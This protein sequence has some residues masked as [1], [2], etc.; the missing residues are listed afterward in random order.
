[1][2]TEVIYCGDN[3]DVLPRYVDDESVDLVYIDPPF[4]T[5]RA[6][7][8]FWGE[9]KERRA[10]DDRFGNA[11]HYLEWMRPRIRAIHEAL[12][13]TGSFC[14]HCDWH[15]SHYV[16]VELDCVFGFNNFQNEIVWYYRGAGLSKKRF[17]RRHD[18]IFWYTKGSEWFFDPDPARQPYAPATVERFSHYI[19]NVRGAHDYGQQR[20]H[21]K[22]KHPDDV[23][24][25]IQPIAPSANVRLGYPTQK[26]R[27]LL[28]RIILTA[29]PPGGVVL[30][31]FCGCGTTLDAATIHKRRWIGV[32]FSPTACRL[33]SDR[34]EQNLGKRPGV[35]FQVRN[36]PKGVAELQRMPPFEFENWAVVALGGIP[37]SVKVGDY[38]IDGRLYVADVG[39]VQTPGQDLFGQID[40][41][42]PIQVKQ[43]RAGR[44]EI[45]KFATA[46]RRDK[47]VRG[48]FIAFG[49]T[50]GSLKE[51]QRA[52][53]RMVLISS[54]SRCKSFSITRRRWGR[55]ILRAWV[56]HHH[57]SP[58]RPMRTGRCGTRT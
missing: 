14:Y 31:P 43:Q 9:A 57:A 41:W 33:M 50:A 45:D 7:E 29:C 19:G 54:P 22:G 2:D 48:Y 26:P 1:M 34:L 12:K 23:W 55:D 24:A 35:D 39:K 40:N 15:A 38:G 3:L 46:M 13:P 58:A 47:R 6:Y 52:T 4:N 27:E 44:P 53:S 42:Y 28:E 20:L 49:F 37:N 32:D 25:D 11:V 10:F 17:A 51:I 8:V 36:L 56:E 16:K 21:P 30:D 5:S 18:V